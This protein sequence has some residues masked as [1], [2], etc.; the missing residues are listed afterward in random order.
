MSFR[1]IS[2]S[3]NQ[4][5]FPKFWEDPPFHDQSGAHRYDQKPSAAKPTLSLFGWATFDIIRQ[6]GAQ[7]VGRSFSHAEDRKAGSVRMS[8]SIMVTSAR[9][10]DL[11]AETRA[12]IIHVCKT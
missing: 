4:A 1:R 6:S 3:I 12:S 7:D 10:E 2:P 11:N 5:V 9:T 8:E